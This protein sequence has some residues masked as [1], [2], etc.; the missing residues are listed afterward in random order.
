[1]LKEELEKKAFDYFYTG[2]CCAEALSKTIIDH[3]AEKPEDYPIKV[4]TGFCG[5]I[6][7]THEDMC[8]ALAGGVL[9]VGYL[10]GRTEKG[11]DFSQVIAITFEFRRQFIE[12]F[13]STNCAAILESFG[14][15]EK[16]IK[17]KQMTGKA[18]GMLYDI[19]IEAKGK[20]ASNND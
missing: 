7:R 5:G 20:Q 2:F 1:M 4:A 12:A 16:Y 11:K 9:A 13:G 6:G 18:A 10:Y 3:F 15:Q 8:G 19:L 14:E 17:C